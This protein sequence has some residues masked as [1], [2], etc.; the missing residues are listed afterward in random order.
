MY[1]T[2]IRIFTRGL[3][4]STGSFTVVITTFVLLWLFELR[5]PFLIIGV[6]SIIVEIVEIYQ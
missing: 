4:R 2:N 6:L 3:Y 5:P 1:D